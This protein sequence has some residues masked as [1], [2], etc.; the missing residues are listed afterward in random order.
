MTLAVLLS[1]ALITGL[2]EYCLP[3]F[4]I[5]QYPDSVI[6][7]CHTARHFPDLSKEEK[8]VILFTNLVRYH[9]AL[10]LEKVARPF[11]EK[12]YLKYIEYD[13]KASHI[14][15]LYEELKNT[16]P[17]PVLQTEAL[18]NETAGEYADYC[19][20]TGTIGHADFPQRWRMIRERLGHIKAGENCNYLPARFNNALFHVISLLIDEDAPQ[21]YG[22]RRAILYKSYQFIGVGIRPFPGHRQVLVQHFSLKKYPSE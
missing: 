4:Y 21:S 1:M 13:A 22:H 2:P 17:M 9:P 15:S 5:G 12:C 3:E 16:A 18:L 14:E 19:N 20:R 6:A 10:F 8:E 7:R 11:I